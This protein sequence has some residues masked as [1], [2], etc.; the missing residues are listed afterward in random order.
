LLLAACGSSRSPG[1]LTAG[2]ADASSGAGGNDDSSGGNASSGSGP[3]DGAPSSGSSGSGASSGAAD[4][5]S[6]ASPEGSSVTSGATSAWYGGV[7]NVDVANV[8]A[9]SNVV[10]VHPNMNANQSMPLGNGKLGVAVWSANG[11][12]AQLNRVDTFPDRKSPGQVVVSGLG[13][14]TGGAGYGGSLDL[15]DAM[16]KESGGGM[17][18]TAYVLQNKDELII[19][20]A[21]ANPTSTQ[22]ATVQLWSGRAPAATANGAFAALAE[23]FVD[24]TTCCGAGG[25]NQTFGSL[26]GLTAGGRNVT[27]AVVNPTTVQVTFNPNADGSF[28]VVVASPAWAGTGD[29]ISTV[30]NLIGADA[31]ASTSSL[32]SAHLAFWHDFWAKTGLLQMGSAEGAYVQ[33]LRDIDLF[34]AAA[35]SAGTVPGHHNGAADL[36]KWNQD[37]WHTGWPVYEFWHWNLRMQVAANLAAGHPELNLPYFNLYTGNLSNIETW[38]QQKYGGNGTDICVPEIM[39]YNGNGAGGAGNEACDQSTTTWNGK[40]LSTGAEVSLWIWSHYLYTGDATFLSNNYPFMAAAAR[41]LLGKAAIG[42]D[43]RRH[44]APSNAHETQWDTQDPTTDIAAMKA[45]FPAV[46]QAAGIL[47]VDTALVSQLQT[48]EGQ[49]LDFPRTDTAT[50]TQLLTS[51]SDA[52]G[53]DMIG[54]SYNPTAARHNSENI[55]L[56]VVWPYG[57]IGDGAGTLTTLAQRT[58]TSRSYVNTPD[59]TYDAVQAARIGNA[60]DFR[61]ALVNQIQTFQVWVS[62]LGNWMNGSDNLPYDELDGDVANAVQEALV[63]DYDG[64]LRI[65]PAWPMAVWDVSGTQYIHGNSR[66]HVQIEGGR[67]VTVV[68][69]AGSTGDITVRNPWGTQSVEVVDGSSGATVIAATPAAQLTIPAQSGSAYVVE[70]VSS[71]IASLRHVQVTTIAATAPRSMGPVTIGVK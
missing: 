36:F 57:L 68:L 69:E 37:T 8:V 33:N 48:A 65:A 21:G 7:F 2:D 34:L 39:R 67:L 29:A 64:L 71:P 56:E 26:A 15:Y 1:G 46:I 31:G 17:T 11:L 63:Q 6:G 40:T 22:T 58:F 47:N 3:A 43:G 66:V 30:T 12:T 53:K 14:L 13:S 32:Q 5:S 9:Q 62:G 51:N 50:Q 4:G 23:A 54:I 42:P 38:T 35:S 41:F 45:L 28:R 61:A 10:L 59:W 18:A 44:T 19:D 24:N 20:V 55:G 70:P 60:A 52:A 25:S 27:A 49:V 16:F